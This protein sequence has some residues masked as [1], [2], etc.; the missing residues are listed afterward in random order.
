M[1][2]SSSEVRLWDVWMGISTIQTTSSTKKQPGNTYEKDILLSLK[3]D[4]FDILEVC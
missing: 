3:L 2:K 4:I 1:I